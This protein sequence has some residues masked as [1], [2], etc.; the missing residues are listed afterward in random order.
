[1]SWLFIEKALTLYSFPL[2][3]ITWIMACIRSAHFTILFQGSGC[4]FISPIKGIQQG[5]A[6]SPYIFILC[7]NILSTLLNHDL[8]EGKLE[9]FQIARN[10]LP[11]TN[12]MYADD[13]PLMGSA[14]SQEIRR[15]RHT[16]DLFCALTGQDFT[17]KI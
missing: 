1:M 11:F 3:F 8:T 13:L 2:I 9:G 10:A 7:M 15:I 14:K 5:C 16:L 4:G 12:L 17:R 6:L